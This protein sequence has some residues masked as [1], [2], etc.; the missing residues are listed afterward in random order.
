MERLVDV[1][2]RDRILVHTYPVT[3]DG[4]DD[5]ACRD[6]AAKAAAYAG[7]VPEA[8]LEGL[9]TRIHVE[10]G[11]PLTPYGDHR[12]ILSQTRRSFEQS[13]RERAY[14]IWVQENC[15]AG[16][17]DDHWC[18]ARDYHLRERAYHLWE[19]EGRPDGQADQHWQETSEFETL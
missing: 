1:L 2:L 11:G 12:D 13:V 19:R 8:E 4:L 3:A 6:K 9:T 7:L 18:R 10:R 16:A 17:A 15:P 14:L 5:A